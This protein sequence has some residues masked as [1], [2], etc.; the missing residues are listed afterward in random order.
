M[1]QEIGMV[2]ELYN[3]YFDAINDQKKIYYNLNNDIKTVNGNI[4][5]TNLAGGMNQ[6][7]IVAQLQYKK[8]YFENSK[9]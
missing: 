5:A 6:Q 9:A 2:L 8:L 3:K 4:H 7:S 1:I